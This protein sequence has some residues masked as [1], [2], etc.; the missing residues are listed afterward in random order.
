MRQDQ[1]DIVPHT[2]ARLDAGQY[3]RPWQPPILAPPLPLVQVKLPGTGAL[4][5]TCKQD[6]LDFLFENWGFPNLL[7]GAGPSLREL[8]TPHLSGG[9]L[10]VRASNINVA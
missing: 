1:C 7:Q 9:Q 2:E 5:K 4:G 10:R 3:W 6:K 8:L